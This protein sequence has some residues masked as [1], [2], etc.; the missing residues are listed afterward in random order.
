MFWSRAV[1]SVTVLLGIA[2]CVAADDASSGEL[3]PESV[4]PAPFIEHE[5]RDIEGWTVQVDIALLAG[6]GVDV[7]DDALQLLQGK[8]HEITL[9]LP[10]ERVEQLRAVVIYLDYEHELESMQYHPGA[11]WL[12]D[13][14]YDPAMEKAV[15]IPRAEGFISHVRNYDQPWCLMHELAHAYHDQV[16]GWEYDPIEA[17]YS[18]A[19]EDGIY[20]SVMRIDGHMERHYALTNA[21]EFFAEM[22]ESY[23]GTN[24]FYPFVRGELREI[25]PD[26]H[27]LLRSIWE[28]E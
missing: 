17:A 9:R 15:H 21:K 6:V 12:S 24:D 16:L 23:L 28:V 18:R 10:E 4:T 14:D 27:A 5:V 20:E 1:L 11:E 8:L 7:G 22:T 3:P 19:S 13:H 25:D 2:W 26:T